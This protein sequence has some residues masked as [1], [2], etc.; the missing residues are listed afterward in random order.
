MH[1]FGCWVVIKSQVYIFLLYIPT[2]TFYKVL[3]WVNEKIKITTWS[4]IF[5]L[6]SANK[7]HN[8]DSV[9]H[10][11]LRN[12]MKIARSRPGRT[13]TNIANLMSVSHLFCGLRTRREGVTVDWLRL[14]R[15]QRPDT[16]RFTGDRRTRAGLWLRKPRYVY[17]MPERAERVK[18]LRLQSR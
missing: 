12:I 15:T 16:A 3:P 4:L 18:I 7:V 1:S 14:E 10:S 13:Q 11:P 6:S 5:P 8:I 2:F 9:R 17:Y